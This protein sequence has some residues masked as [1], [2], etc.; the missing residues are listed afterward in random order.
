M[1]I[2]AV[3][4]QLIGLEF[5]AKRFWAKLGKTSPRTH[6]RQ[7]RLKHRWS[8]SN[9]NGIEMN[10]SQREGEQWTAWP[11]SGANGASC[12]CGHNTNKRSHWQ[13]RPLLRHQMIGQHG[14]DEFFLPARWLSVAEQ[15]ANS[16]IWICTSLHSLATANYLSIGVQ[17][18]SISS[19]HRRTF[20][21]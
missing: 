2:N 12:Q 6:T 21:I 20:D 15:L 9:A 13:K 18:K 3:K 1:L 10:C 7:P 11:S 19:Q 17:I 4:L 16:P 14:D 8:I 5:G